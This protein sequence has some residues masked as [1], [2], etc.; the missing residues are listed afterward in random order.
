MPESLYHI[1]VLDCL[2]NASSCVY[3]CLFKAP[4][5]GFLLDAYQVDDQV[6][7]MYEVPDAGIIS[8]IE[9][10]DLVDLCHI[11]IVLTMYRYLLPACMDTGFLA[12]SLST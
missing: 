7:A 6:G 4:V 8:G 9:I 12:E 5:H 10:F 2:G 3:V 1:V 11:E